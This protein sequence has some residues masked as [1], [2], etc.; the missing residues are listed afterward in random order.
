VISFAGAGPGAS[1]LITIRAADRLARAD[2]VI[3][4]GSLVAS[5]LLDRCRPG[6]VLY[7]SSRMTLGEIT[8]VFAA[9]PDDDIVRLHSGDPTMF[10]AVAEQ[11]DWCRAHGRPYEIVPGVSSVSA[12]AA[13]AGRELTVPGVAQTVVLTRLARRTAASVPDNESVAALARQGAT[14]ALYLS[15]GDPEALQ[16]ELL[17][18]GSAYTAETPA[19]IG[20]KVSWPEEIVRR[21]TLGRLADDLTALGKRTSVMILVGEALADVDVPSVSHVYSAGFGHAFRPVR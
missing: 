1:D 11:I 20:Y 2:V 21:S 19:V 10:S 14:M 3:W 17:C 4:A 16:Q 9:H 8:G 13:A 5:S 12:T 15:A 6:A 18:E 7:D